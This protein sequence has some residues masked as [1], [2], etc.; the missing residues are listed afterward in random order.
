MAGK[1]V[2]VH[3]VLVH[4]LTHA[5]RPLP[6]YPRAWH[7]PRAGLSGD[8]KLYAARAKIRQLARITRSARR[9]A[10]QLKLAS[11]APERMPR[12]QQH[13]P[14]THI[15]THR[16]PFVGPVMRTMMIVPPSHSLSFYS[17]AFIAY[18]R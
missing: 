18:Y 13:P 1:G 2:R 12:R 16:P 4:E 15:H 8:P 9:Q 11:G 5:H 17:V 10:Q 6:S 3:T 14:H 7:T